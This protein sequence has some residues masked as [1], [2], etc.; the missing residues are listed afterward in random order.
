M[1]H[2]R[3]AATLVRLTMRFAI[4]NMA[5]TLL[6]ADV[7]IASTDPQAQAETEQAIEY[8]V[9]TESMLEDYA[10]VGIES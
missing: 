1:P 6:D 10:T 5:L 7:G 2:A 9:Y 4:A 3:P 8:R